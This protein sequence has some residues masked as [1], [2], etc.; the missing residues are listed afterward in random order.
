MISKPPPIFSKVEPLPP[1]K[2]WTEVL[3]EVGYP[4]DVVVLDFETYYDQEFGLKSLTVPEYVSDTRFEVLGLSWLHVHTSQPHVDPDTITTMEVGEEAVD[5]HFKYLQGKYGENLERCTVILQNAMFDAFVMAARYHIYPPHIIDTLCLARAYHTRSRHGLEHLCKK[6]HL[7]DKGDTKQLLR[8]TFKRRFFRP[9]KGPPQQRPIMTPEQ[10]KG[11]CEYANN[12]VARTFDLLGILLPKLSNPAIELRIQHLTL[13]MA[14]VPRL[15]YDEALGNDLIA[16]MEARMTKAIQDIDLTGLEWLLDGPLHTDD[17]TGNNKFDQL[18]TDAL[19]RAGDNPMNYVKFM[20]SGAKFELA[21]DDPGLPKLLNHANPQVS[22]LVRART[23][24][25]SWPLHV[26]RVQSIA[27]MAAACSGALPVPLN[28]HGAHTGRDSG[29]W[30]VNFQ[31]FPK[32]GEA[33]LVA[34]RGL[35]KAPPGYILP[36]V[37][38]SAIEAR[39]VAWA[40]NQADLI[41]TFAANGDVYCQFGSGFYGTRVRKPAKTDPPAVATLMKER[42]N[43]SKICVLGMGYGMGK[44]RFA[45]YANCDANTAEKAVG[46]Y[47]RTYTA[48]VKF[49]YDVEAAFVRCANYKRP[50]VCGPI[51]FYSTPDVDVVM[52]LPNGRHLNYHRVKLEADDRGGFRPSVFNETTKIH[53]HL[54]GGVLCLTG[55]TP[56]LTDRGWVALCRVRLAD[57]VWDGL[58]W[59][60]H[61]GVLRKGWK[62]VIYANGI[63]ITPTHEILTWEGW[64]P[65]GSASGLM[66]EGVWTP[67]GIVSTSFGRQKVV[68]ES[69]LPLWRRV[70]RLWERLDS[71]RRYKRMQILLDD[72]EAHNAWTFPPSSL[73]YL[74]EYVRQVPAALTSGVAQ[75]WRAGNRGLRTV[76]RIVRQLL[77]RHGADV[78]T[79]QDPQGPTYPGP[80]EQRRELRAGQLPMGYIH[81][82]GEQQEVFDLADCGPRHRFTVMDGNGIAR[83]VHNCENLVQAISRDV[84]MEASLR[85]EDQG[86]HSVHRVHDELILCCP[87][88]D[89]ER[90]LAATIRELSVTPAWAPGLPLNAEGVL[91]ER[92]GLH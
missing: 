52:I 70:R 71:P 88:E 12:D 90:V 64:T 51:K 65:A 68:L 38:L 24:L 42:R 48:I 41:E 5:R 74:A 1:A 27:S 43:F 16:R 85:L 19:K 23:A 40:A 77:G 11:M 72:G 75:L 54:W 15:R 66:W 31:N 21:K 26:S 84:M 89:G 13:E 83:L 50:T 17:I 87:V 46:F 44:D 55:E 37:D 7:K 67:D 36:I 33:E 56:V 28:Y 86:M 73:R 39:V 3:R 60:R 2:H 53:D 29:C 62:D 30:G 14:T 6:F 35:L 63:G 4:K 22:G 10:V 80:K 32:R 82:T 59:V 57:K 25:K 20:K 58:S 18:L 45:E 34:M 49:W 92:Y 91:S 78:P 61:G 69:T 47:R 76:G 79:G 81:P 8:A 9:K